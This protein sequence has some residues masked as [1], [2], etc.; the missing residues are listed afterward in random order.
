MFSHM[1]V[2]VVI[3]IIYSVGSF[4]TFWW[5]RPRTPHTWTDSLVM[6]PIPN[7]KIGKTKGK[8]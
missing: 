8:E 2:I 1:H 5:A 3:V 4:C 7:G 6:S